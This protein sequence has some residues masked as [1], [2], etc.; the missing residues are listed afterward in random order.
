MK[1]SYPIKI[2][3]YV[4]NNGISDEPAFAWWLPYKTKKKKVIISKLRSKYWQI[5]HKYGERIPN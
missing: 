4:V 1:Y 3:E 2:V 5:T